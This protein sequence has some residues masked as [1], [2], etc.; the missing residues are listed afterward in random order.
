MLNIVLRDI[1]DG[2]YLAKY[3][4]LYYIMS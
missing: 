2:F 3:Y 4:N 1:W